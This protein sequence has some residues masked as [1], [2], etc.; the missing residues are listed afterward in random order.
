MKLSTMRFR[1]QAMVVVSD[2]DQGNF[3]PGKMR[4]SFDEIVDSIEDL[5][6]LMNGMAKSLIKQFK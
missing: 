4:Y 6:S 3:Q 1:I 5:P 2:A